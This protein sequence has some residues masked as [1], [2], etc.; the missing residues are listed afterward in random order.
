MAEVQSPAGASKRA[1]PAPSK[2][3]AE[4]SERPQSKRRAPRRCRGIEQWPDAS[5]R[6]WRSDGPD[7]ERQSAPAARHGRVPPTRHRRESLRK[8]K[9]QPRTRR[10]Q[11]QGLLPPAIS[12]KRCPG[13]PEAFELQELDS[14]ITCVA[15]KY[16]TTDEL[17]EM[18][19]KPLL[20]L[21]YQ[22]SA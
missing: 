4:P 2:R 20:K 1:P 18:Y 15:L 8:H 17:P 19:D 13:R 3:D 16:R 9:P 12:R 11:A 5:L 7:V 6:F 22:G 14:K 21:M 10:T